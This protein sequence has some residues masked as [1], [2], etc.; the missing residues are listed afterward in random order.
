V[1]VVEVVDRLIL[2][3]RFDIFYTYVYMG[4][5]S[6]YLRC[7][8][9]QGP[10]RVRIIW[11]FT[12]SIIEYCIFC[13][14]HLAPSCHADLSMYIICLRRIPYCIPQHSTSCKRIRI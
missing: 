8:F 11:A 1:E 4:V 14:S 13:F 10:I 12:L 6:R 7:N 3:S 9:R 5:V 2:I